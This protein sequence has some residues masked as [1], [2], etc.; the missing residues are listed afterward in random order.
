MSAVRRSTKEEVN[1]ASSCDLA[2][3]RL[4]SCAGQLGSRLREI[5]PSKADRK[6]AIHETTKRCNSTTTT[7]TTSV[8]SNSMGRTYTMDQGCRDSQS[9]TLQRIPAQNPWMFSIFIGS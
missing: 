5:G 8:D 7:T 1:L 6:V 4:L 9:H 3:P 2:S